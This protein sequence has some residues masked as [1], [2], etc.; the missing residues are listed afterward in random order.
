L[1]FVS[2]FCLK[3]YRYPFITRRYSSVLQ[4]KGW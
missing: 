2:S 1:R 4:F 3:T